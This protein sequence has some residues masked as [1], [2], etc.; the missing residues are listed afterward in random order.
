MSVGLGALWL[1]GRDVPAGPGSSTVSIVAGTSSLC[2][3][4][5]FAHARIL[6][7]VCA[8]L[9]L[10]GVHGAGQGYENARSV[11]RPWW[12]A[13]AAVR[14]DVRIHR[15]LTIA[16]QGGRLFALRDEEFTVGRLGPVYRSG[17]PGWLVGTELLWRIP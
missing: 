13:G 15:H 5:A 1:P 14:L 7:A 12:V 11:W 4:L 16:G 6:P 10:G 8:Q 3:G 17:D 2:G 9:G